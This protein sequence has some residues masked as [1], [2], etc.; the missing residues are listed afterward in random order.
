AGSDP[1]RDVID[2]IVETGGGPP[3]T[4]VSFAFVADHRIHRVHSFVGDHSGNT[5]EHEVEQRC[6]NRVAH[7]FG[8][9][10]EDGPDDFGFREMLRIATD[11]APD[12][13]TRVV[14]IT[15]A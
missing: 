13:K 9:R 6:N 12:E 5:E 11:K 14:D 2:D 7:V 10:L 4:D 15:A 1:C 3:E 8:D